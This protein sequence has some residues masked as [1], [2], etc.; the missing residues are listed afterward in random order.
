MSNVI[1]MGEKD[2][3][4]YKSLGEKVNDFLEEHPLFY[5]KRRFH[6]IASGLN[7]FLEIYHIIES[8]CS[9]VVDGWRGEQQEEDKELSAIKLYERV[10]PLYRQEPTLEEFMRDLEQLCAMG[11]LSRNDYITLY[12]VLNG[13]VGIDRL[14]E[15]I[16]R[17]RGRTNFRDKSGEII[18]FTFFKG[19]RD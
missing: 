13:E 18:E 16:N 3:D 4:F 14:Y 15:K 11:K 2:P 9:A 8:I 17:L 6:G 19:K 10:I 5:K 1:Y 7:C 12:N